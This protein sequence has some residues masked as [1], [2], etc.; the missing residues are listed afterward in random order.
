[1]SAPPRASVYAHLILL[2]DAFNNSLDAPREFALVRE[3]NFALVIGRS[4]DDAQVV[5][6][7]EQVS[8]RHAC[9]ECN[10]ADFVLI[11]L[12]SRNG[13]YLNGEKISEPC[14]LKHGD[15]IGLRKLNRAFRFDVV[16][17]TKPWIG[18]LTRDDG[19]GIFRVGQSEVR[20]STLERQL[21][22]V[23]FDG[24]GQFVSR[25]DIAK[26]VYDEALYDPDRD[27][28]R[29]EKLVSRLR[30]KLEDM[31]EEKR[32][33]ES[34]HEYGYKLNAGDVS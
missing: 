4:P 25:K 14:A 19:T 24:A 22:N 26:A 11:D 9:I 30:E 17:I 18:V 34:D 16:K 21:L 12:G 13:T 20:L 31:D 5:L 33:V 32:W 3:A 6:D 8:R 7:D 2:N 10:G 1:M 28:Q 29:I 27:K 15:V 23:L